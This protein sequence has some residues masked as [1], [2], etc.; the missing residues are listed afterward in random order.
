MARLGLGFSGGFGTVAARFLTALERRSSST[1]LPVSGSFWMNFFS[2]YFER[3]H[4]SFSPLGGSRSTTMESPDAGIH[5]QVRKNSF[6]SNRAKDERT[7][8]LKLGVETLFP[9][10]RLF[11]LAVTQQREKEEA[12]ER[13]IKRVKSARIFHRW[14]VFLTSLMS[15]VICDGEAGSDTCWEKVQVVKCWKLEPLAQLA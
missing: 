2:T 9:Y 7:K 15:R 1:F 10:L 8:E 12:T 4:V 3:I 14:C 5:Q 6:F 13:V 11:L